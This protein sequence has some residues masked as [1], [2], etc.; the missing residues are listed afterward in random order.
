MYGFG[1]LDLSV[2]GVINEM[3]KIVNDKE[4]MERLIG[5]GL[6]KKENQ[7][8]A[9]CN[10]IADNTKFKKVS[11][12]HLHDITFESKNRRFRLEIIDDNTYYLVYKYHNGNKYVNSKDKDI[13][14]VIGDFYILRKWFKKRNYLK[15]VK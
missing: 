6:S 9:L 2:N 13:S 8:L 15:E 14:S 12:N 4:E 1:N 7:L 3:K 11:L 10:Y 5:N